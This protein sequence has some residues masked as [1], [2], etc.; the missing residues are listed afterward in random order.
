MAVSSSSINVASVTVMAIS[1]GLTSLV[2]S[3][4]VERTA[5][6]GAIFA[7]CSTQMAD[8]TERSQIMKRSI[9][10]LVAPKGHENASWLETAVAALAGTQDCSDSVRRNQGIDGLVSISRLGT[11]FPAFAPLIAGCGSN[12]L[13][14]S[15]AGEDELNDNNFGRLDATHL[16]HLRSGCGIRRS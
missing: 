15:I 4:L 3:V 7:S 9:G 6:A 5:V 14:A 11:R 10:I 12:P 2:R 16:A 1:H 8:E 13:S